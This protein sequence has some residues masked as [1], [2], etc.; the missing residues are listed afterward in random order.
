MPTNAPKTAKPSKSIFDP[1]VS[2]EDR[3][4]LSNATWPDLKTFADIVLLPRHQNSSATGHQRAD[5]RLSG[6]TSWRDSRNSK[7]GEQFSG[8]AGGG[9]RVSDTVGAGSLDF[10]KDVRDDCGICGCEDP[11]RRHKLTLSRLIGPDGE[12]RMGSGCERIEDK[13]PAKSSRGLAR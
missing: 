6:S 3:K 4:P 9:K 2:P 10:G 5:N 7:L 11:L 12:R 13:W 8:G 1:F